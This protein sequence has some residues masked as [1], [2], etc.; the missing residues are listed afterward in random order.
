MNAYY[1]IT[2]G[3]VFRHPTFRLVREN[4]DGERGIWTH[5]EPFCPRCGSG[6]VERTEEG[7]QE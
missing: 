1:C 7:E 5:E 2:C 4:L 3:L 6:D